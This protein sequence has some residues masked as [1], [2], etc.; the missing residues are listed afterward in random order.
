[1]DKA[2][3]TFC[4]ARSEDNAD[5]TFIKSSYATICEKCVDICV[6]AIQEV[7]EEK[8]VDAVD[9]GTVAAEYREAMTN[10]PMRWVI[11]GVTY[12][13]DHAV[14]EAW[15]ASL[16][17]PRAVPAFAQPE[18]IRSLAEL[19]RLLEAAKTIDPGC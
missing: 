9:A 19:K 15:R 11:A 16:Q 18:R 1:M 13:V 5:I 14:L 3:C 7:K 6:D 8:T 12:W 4:S 10:P 2:V 17:I